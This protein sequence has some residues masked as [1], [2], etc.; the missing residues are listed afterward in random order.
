MIGAMIRRPM[1]SSYYY[2][3]SSRGRGRRHSSI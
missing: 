1:A 3:T 2:A